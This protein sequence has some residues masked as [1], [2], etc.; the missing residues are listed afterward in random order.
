MDPGRGMNLRK[1]GRGGG[2]EILV[3]QVRRVKDIASVPSRKTV[4]DCLPNIVTNGLGDFAVQPSWIHNH[5]THHASLARTGTHPARTRHAPRIT[6]THPQNDDGRHWNLHI[7]LHLY[8][9]ILLLPYQAASY[10]LVQ[11]DLAQLTR[12]HFHAPR[13]KHVCTHPARTTHRLHGKILGM[14]DTE[15]TKI[16]SKCSNTTIRINLENKTILASS[17]FLATEANS[18]AFRTSLSGRKDFGNDIGFAVE[19]GS[20]SSLAEAE[21][22]GTA[23]HTL[24]GSAD[25]SNNPKERTYQYRYRY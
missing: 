2:Q 11:M 13:T 25:P 17:A 7:H 23:D 14:S 22:E 3:Y 16:E 20:R 15:S 1:G 5:H 18:S 4:V 9:S 19:W 8:T 10:V 12:T 24:Q 21:S 6:C